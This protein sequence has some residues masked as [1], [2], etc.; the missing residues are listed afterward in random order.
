MGMKISVNHETLP[1]A[2]ILSVSGGLMDAYSYICRGQVFANAQ[3]GN[4][5]LFGVNL[6]SG[7]FQI[8]LRYFVPVLAFALGIS[9]AE[10]IKHLFTGKQTIHW[11]RIS[12]AAEI[13]ILS[14]VAFI[15]QSLNLA[16]NSLTSFACG[17]QVESF[18][19]VNDS[20]V[21]TTMCIGNLRAAVQSFC[22][23]GYTKNKKSIKN[24]LLYFCLIAMFVVGAVIGNIFIGALGE[25][26]IL[27]S[28]ILLTADLVLLLVNRQ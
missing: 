20:G 17:I 16:A 3:T 21:A 4:I 1:F 18:R 8:A 6:A 9:A 2:V 15:P 12:L 7:N 26:A 13:V 10:I 28:S 24:S 5:L 27:V 14:C 11:S 22:D 25:K 19:K 23:Y